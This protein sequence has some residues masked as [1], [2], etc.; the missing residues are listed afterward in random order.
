MKDKKRRN[1]SLFARAAGLL[2]LVLLMPI[3]MFAQ[4]KTVTGTVTDSEG[5][6]VI[7]ATV[8]VKGSSRATMTDVNGAFSIAAEA[9]SVL[10]I[11]SIGYT[12]KE[13]TVGNQ[14]RIHVT[15]EGG[16]TELDEVV[17]IGYGT[18][19]R[20]DLTGAI[21]SVKAADLE[22]VASSNAMQALQGRVPGL[23]ITQSDG[24]AGG[25][26]SMTVR[27]NRSI[28]ASDAP[29]IL[30]N[31]VDYGST[32]DISASDIESMEV[33]K[34]AASTAIYGSRG[35]N[36]IIII[37][38]KDG[39]AGK[40]R[41]NFNAYVSSNIPTN[42]ARPLQGEKEVQALIDRENYYKDYASGNWGEYQATAAE[43]L[44][45]TP[46]NLPVGQE[47]TA[48]DVYNSGKYVDWF[49]LILQNGF[50]QN[51]DAS[52]SGGNDKTTFN[53][54]LGAMLEQGLMKND[55]LDRYNTRINIDH[56]ISKY[57]KVGTNMTLS[58]R[59]QDARNSSVFGQ[60]LKMTSIT[61]THNED[62]S[63]IYTPNAFYKAHVT[64][65]ADEVEGVWSKNRESTRLFGNIYTEIT[66]IKGLAL[67][68]AVNI[69]RRN[70]R[71][72]NYNDYQ[73][74]GNY[75]TPKSTIWLDYGMTTGYTWDNTLNY[76]HQFGSQHELTAMLGTSATKSV[77]EGLS[78]S[79]QA[80]IEH[81]FVSQFYDI[82]KIGQVTPESSYAKTTLLSF[83]GRVIYSYAGKYILN[84]TVRRDGTSVLAEGHQWDNFPSA[85][86]AWRVID[87]NFMEGTKSWL[88]NL[89]LR[90]SYGVSGNAAVDAYGTLGGLSDQA[91]YYYYGGKDVVGY[92]PSKVSNKSLDWEK[93]HATNLGIDFG[94]LNNRINA[95]VDYYITK[96]N[97]LI[98]MKVAPATSIFPTTTANVGDS[99]GSG[100]EIAVNALAVKTKDFSWD[101]N[102]SYAYNKNEVVALT[103][104]VDK[105]IV[106]NSGNIV[107]EPINIYYDYEAA[108]IW[109]V[110]EYD[111][112]TA[113]WLARHPDKT[114]ADLGYVAYYGTPGTIKVTDVNDDGKI[115][116]DDKIT[117]NRS[118]KHI[119]GMTNTF[120]YKNLSLSVLLYARTGAYMSYGL[121]SQMYFEPQWQNWGD[122][123]YW[124]PDGKDHKFPSPGTTDANTKSINNGAYRTA[125]T[126]VSSDYLKIKDITL[127]YTLPQSWV[128]AAHISNV[129]IYGSLKNFF[130]FSATGDGYD[131]ERGG[132]T[133]FPL[134]KQAVFGVN[135]QF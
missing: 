70:Y 52:V 13:I 131:S 11:S 129:K 111:Q 132:A 83:F 12:D 91:L 82:S 50:T 85:S 21:S 107:G 116:D 123:D 100:V 109:N 55:A 99:K 33:L 77:S 6:A 128:K 78:A 51:Y 53:I 45:D 75:Q 56:K 32:I 101:V 48:L 92:L 34:D 121:Y 29:L 38:T 59:N 61:R 23:D 118:P 2:A 31:G 4:T 105:N 30:V 73:S 96:T 113:D 40:T 89:K 58:Y 7:G 27:G 133:T 79:G 36:G 17:S 28:T 97:D 114:A 72:G 106:G 90:A 60:A 15:L 125:L 81:Y 86:L 108:G 19:K 80:G 84:V 3:M 41:V 47:F 110:G 76:S 117:Y 10:K 88:S 24:Q 1:G 63:L 35:A 16:A 98:Y 126:Y 68:S 37:T 95:T 120:T 102:L 9:Q 112:Y 20:R 65:L 127:S 8:A 5:E 26:M 64:P 43:V 93:T 18:V 46:D 71:E 62:G 135:I 115:D 67:R 44:N 122:L 39:K 66:P 42:Y 130:T 74:V 104:G 103:E 22:K 69:Q 57:V 49:D 14:T 134:A 54:S 25:S 94:F 124:V 87:E 119:F